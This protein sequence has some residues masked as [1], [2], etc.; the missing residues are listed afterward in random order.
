MSRYIFLFFVIIFFS[1]PSSSHAKGTVSVGDIIPHSLN[2]KDQNER[3]RSFSDLS[4]KKGVILVFVR[5]ADWCPYCQ[6]Q[7]IDLDK[8]TKR[9]KD[10]GYNLVSVSY[11]SFAAMRK[12][13]TKNKP[14][15]VML[16]DP[17]SESIRAFGILNEAVAKG[18]ISYGVPY[19]GVYVI[20]KDKKV[21]AKFFEQGYKERPSTGEILTKIEALNPPQVPAMTIESMGTDP[22]LPGQ[23]FVQIP[24]EELPPLVLPGAPS[25]DE[26]IDIVEDIIEEPQPPEMPYLPAINTEETIQKNIDNTQD[27]FLSDIPPPEAPII[28]EDILDENE[29]Y[30]VM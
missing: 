24:T 5:S 17:R 28:D 19:P 2:L 25:L 7:L 27:D 11:D 4:G 21:Q 14:S 22:I 1:V 15:M 13:V 16:S 18:T 20:G 12:F 10:L 23:E 3:L 30:N 9:F 26:E 6:K 29:V 8:S